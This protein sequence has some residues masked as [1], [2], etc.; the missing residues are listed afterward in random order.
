MKINRILAVA[1]GMA[2]LAAALSAGAQ[3]GQPGW[4]DTV[5]GMLGNYLGQYLNGQQSQAQS[6]MTDFLADL[7]RSTATPGAPP[8]GPGEQPFG[9]GGQQNMIGN[10]MDNAAAQYGSDGSDNL[11]ALFGGAARDALSQFAPTSGE[12]RYLSELMRAVYQPP[13]VE[14]GTVPPLPPPPPDTI[15]RCMMA[16]GDQVALQTNGAVVSSMSGRFVGQLMQSTDPRCPYMFQYNGSPLC[17]ATNGYVWSLQPQ[18]P[19]PVGQCQQ[20]FW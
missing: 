2:T 20:A 7:A 8:F 14:G 9:P 11:N 15:A 17:V 5:T 13:G 1:V 12:Y 18:Y 19:Q 4:Q 16:S 10:I 6:G 3:G